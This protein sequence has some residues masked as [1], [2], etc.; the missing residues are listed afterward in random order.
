MST[1]LSMASRIQWSKDQLAADVDREVVILSIE[2]GSYYGLDDIGSEIWQLL[3][4]P[5][6]V[7]AVCDAL[8]EKYDASRAVIERDVLAL[9]EQLAAE[10]LITMVA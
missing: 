5:I 10:G 1:T 2:R 7:S 4:A 8:A 9:L 3:E 6:A